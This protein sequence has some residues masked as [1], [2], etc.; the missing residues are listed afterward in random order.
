MEST[1]MVQGPKSPCKCMTRSLELLPRQ[2]AAAPLWFACLAVCSSA[3][4]MLQLA[5]KQ[6]GQVPGAAWPPDEISRQLRKCFFGNI[7]HN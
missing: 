2:P 7:M 1:P 6:L 3:T 5:F 4:G